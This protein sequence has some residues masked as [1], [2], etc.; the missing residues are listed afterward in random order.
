[1]KT[2]LFLIACLT[3]PLAVH[4]GPIVQ[5]D[6]MEAVKA[7]REGHYDQALGLL[8]KQLAR[9]AAGTKDSHKDYFFT[10]FEWTQ[11]ASDYAPARLAMIAERDEQVRKLLG[12]DATFCA[13]GFTPISRFYVIADMNKFLQDDRSTYRVFTQLLADYPALAQRE[14]LT[15]LPAIVES[16]DYG[17]AAQYLKDPLRRLDHLNLLSRELPLYPPPPQPPRLAVELGGFMQDVLLLSKTFKGLGKDAEA[18]SLRSAAL[19]GIQSEELRT[20]AVQ[21]LSTPGS[22]IRTV[23]E[24]QLANEAVQTVRIPPEATG[25]ADVFVSKTEIRIADT[26]VQSPSELVEVLAARNIHNVRVHASAEAGYERIG[27]VIYAVTRAGGPI[28]L[29]E[30]PEH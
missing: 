26:P 13:D 11:L 10:M 29:A 24:H 6:M 9:I 12:G 15:A 16:G 14:S 22:I 23:T 5:P 27:K 17:L 1:M 18:E 2:I 8:K 19:A 30:I 21:E 25:S 4:A 20:L 7:H 28:D 3:A